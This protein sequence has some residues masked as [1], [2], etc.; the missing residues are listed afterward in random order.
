MNVVFHVVLCLF[1]VIIIYTF[2]LCIEFTDSLLLE[3]VSVYFAPLSDTLKIQSNF[4]L[5]ESRIFITW[6]DDKLY[7]VCIQEFNI[8]RAH[9]VWSLL[10][11]RSMWLWPFFNTSETP[12]VLIPFHLLF[13]PL[14]NI[15]SLFSISCCN[16]QNK[17]IQVELFIWFSVQFSFFSM[18]THCRNTW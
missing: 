8:A 5:S 4:L 3:A 11:C 14:T 9:P 7:P 10:N 6:D 12:K 13:C 1:I 18:S 17:T 15:N 2:Y 16:M